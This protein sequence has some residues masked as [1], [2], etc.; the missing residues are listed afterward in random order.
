MRP[1]MPRLNFEVQHWLVA[2]EALVGCFVS[3]SFAGSV[4]ELIG[5]SVAWASSVAMPS[6]FWASA[7]SQP[8][9]S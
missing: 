5:D 4:V 7:H 6:S 3:M 2:K 8:A 1:E 9:T